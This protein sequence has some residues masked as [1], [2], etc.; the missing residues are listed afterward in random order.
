MPTCRHC[1]H[2]FS[3]WPQF[4]AHLN[5]QCCPVLHLGCVPELPPY[6]PDPA[7]L[8]QDADFLQTVLTD[9]WQQLAQKIRV[10]GRLHYCPICNLWMAKTSMLHQHITAQHADE[11]AHFDQYQHFLLTRKGIRSP[12]QHCGTRHNRAAVGCSVLIRVALI[13]HRQDRLG[14]HKS[15]SDKAKGD[16]GRTDKRSRRDGPV[17][18]HDEQA[19]R[20]RAQET[21]RQGGRLRSA[22]GKAA[23]RSGQGKLGLHEAGQTGLRAFFTGQRGGGQLREAVKLITT[24][25]LRH[26]DALAIHRQDTSYVFFMKTS[27]PEVTVLSDLLRVGTEWK[28]KKEQTPAQ[29]TQP[30][31]RV[32]LLGCLLE[33]VAT[34]MQSLDPTLHAKAQAAKL[35]NPAGD[36]HY[37]MWD[38]AEK[39]YQNKDDREPI[40]TKAV[41]EDLAILQRLILQPRVVG[42]FHAQRKLTPDMQGEVVPFVLEVGLRTQASHEVYALLDK[43]CHQAIWHLAGTSL[44]HDKLGRGALANALEKIAEKL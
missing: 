3:S 32:V 30:P 39:I 24:L 37:M 22:E 10:L 26:E 34:R 36:F 35:V 40:P 28:T 12:C 11:A 43:Y 1:R 19:G 6:P 31:L 15:V 8:L 20:G 21:G 16:N 14:I 29:V 23:R 2:E 4:A 44:R 42:R 13:F 17:E 18:V 9:D 25:S 7:P 27:P 38:D 41:Q 5:R 33:A